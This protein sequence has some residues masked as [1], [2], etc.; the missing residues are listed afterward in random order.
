MRAGHKAGLKLLLLGEYLVKISGQH[1][2]KKYVQNVM[3][4]LYDHSYKVYKTTKKKII[5]VI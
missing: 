1:L 4:G 3:N 2:V 5:V